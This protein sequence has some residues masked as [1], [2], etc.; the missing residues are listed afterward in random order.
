MNMDIVLPIIFGIQSPEGH[1]EIWLGTFIGIQSLRAFGNVT[2]VQDFQNRV[3]KHAPTAI[4][5]NAGI[6]HAPC[7]KLHMKSKHT[8]FDKL[9]AWPTHVNFQPR[10]K[11]QPL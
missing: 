11:H 3:D 9:G 10:N 2:G 4:F 7:N 5:K 1:L 6:R 8:G